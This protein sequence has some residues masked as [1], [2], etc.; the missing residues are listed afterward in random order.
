MTVERVKN[1]DGEMVDPRLCPYC[2]KRKRGWRANEPDALC[3]ACD[4]EPSITELD[5]S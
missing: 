3:A 2:G 4:K 5:A 1:N